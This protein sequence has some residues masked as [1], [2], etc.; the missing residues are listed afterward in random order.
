M[1]G[2]DRFGRPAPRPSAR[3]AV[4]VVGAGLRRNPNRV[5]ILGDSREARN[6]KVMTSTTAS[7]VSGT[8]VVLTST[9][10]PGALPGSFVQVFGTT[11]GA[12]D[13]RYTIIA[14]PSAAA[15]T[16]DCPAA[17]GQSTIGSPSFFVGGQLADT[18]WFVSGNA[19]LGAPFQLVRNSGVGGQRTDQ[20]L[21]RIQADALD[22]DADWIIIGGGI[23]D[24]IQSTSEAATTAAL[25]EMYDRVLAD[26]K[27][28]GAL[29]C[30]PYGP[31]VSGYSTAN[32]QKISRINQAIRAYCAEN[33]DCKLID[34]ALAMTDSTSGAALSGVLASDDA[35][36][37]VLGGRIGGS[38][39]ER[40]MRGVAVRQDREIMSAL[41]GYDSDPSSWNLLTNPVLAGTSTATSWTTSGSAGGHTRSL[42]S[43]ADGR[44][45]W[46]QDIFV[47]SAPGQD[48]VFSSADISALLT[49]GSTIRCGCELEI[50]SGLSG[51]Q[52]ITVGLL[53]TIGGVTAYLR[54][55]SQEL[56]YATG[57]RV[58][59]IAQSLY[60]VSE[61]WTIPAGLS[62]SAAKFE[63][64]VR[65]G[66]GGGAETITSRFGV[67]WVSRD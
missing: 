66:A 40:A 12:Y 41:D 27:R 43:R 4:G 10:I 39:F 3:E 54:A 33:A 13:G 15:L 65:S 57:G 34:F 22:I 48:S 47:P 64:R 30:V 29:T 53:M 7:S 56:T 31:A 6:N 37:S 52:Y 11:G 23:N 44:G 45:N 8:N 67:P 2:L 60:L 42:I 51:I 21:D 38:V 55:W 16:F 26:G 5:V 20:I 63:I 36:Y 18:G 62:I 32:L 25:Y 35:H 28:C 24:I 58:P 49:A 19:Q 59:D 50:D 46:Q 9:A 61:Q 14:N 17:V 1:S